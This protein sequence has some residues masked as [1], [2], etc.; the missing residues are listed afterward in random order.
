MSWRIRL[1]SA[2]VHYAG[3]MQLHTALSGPISALD[4]LYLLIEDGSTVIALGEIRENVEYL[5]GLPAQQV[6][7]LLLNA[8]DPVAWNELLEGNF[9]SFEDARDTL[10]PLPRALLDCT[11]RDMGARTC[12]LPLAEHVGGRSVDAVETNQCL[13]LT[14]PKPLVETAQDYV[15]RGFRQLKLRVGG[16]PFDNDLNRLRALRRHFGGDIELAIDANG[17]WPSEQAMRYLPQLEPFDLSYIEQPV[18]IDDWGGLRR[19]IDLSPAPVMLDEMATGLD[20]VRG[21]ISS[22]LNIWLHLK[23]PKMGGITPLLE[24]ASLLTEKAIPFMIGQ[25]NEGGAATA[26]AIHCVMAARPRFAELYGADGLMDDP[27]SGVLYGHG[28][29]GVPDIPGLGVTFDPGKC[30]CLW[31]KQL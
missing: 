22:E 17:Q 18:P 21:I 11:L 23:I 28:T 19:V 27:I 24:A 7:K 29:V 4:E 15:E 2:S 14:G 25:M 10:P 8:L 12:S 26:A 16:G 5:S 9:T 3:G 31:E 30:T 20:A 1:L 13:Q 6:R